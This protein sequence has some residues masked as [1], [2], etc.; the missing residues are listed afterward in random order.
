MV[1]MR[2]TLWINAMTEYFEKSYIELTKTNHHEQ[3]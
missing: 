2:A 3:I 1:V